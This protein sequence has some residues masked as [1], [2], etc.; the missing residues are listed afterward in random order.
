MIW[1]TITREVRRLR[2][3]DA[4]DADERRDYWFAR[5]QATAKAAALA[6]QAMECPGL[7]GPVSEDLSWSLRCLEVG[8]LFCAALA[9]T[10]GAR[11]S[12]RA[13]WRARLDHLCAR[14]EARIPSASDR[15][16]FDP[17]GG[18]IGAWQETLELLRSLVSA[19]D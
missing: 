13:G 11:H 17:L 9:Q 1:H 8:E 16:W 12:P 2:G 4:P 14:L 10:Y 19:M 5:R 6:R 7:A 3:G 18:D 15:E